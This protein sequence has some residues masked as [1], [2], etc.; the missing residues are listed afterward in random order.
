MISSALPLKSGKIKRKGEKESRLFEEARRVL[1]PPFEWHNFSRVLTLPPS[2]LFGT[3]VVEMAVIAM[4]GNQIIVGET[5]K[6]LSKET[7]APPPLLHVG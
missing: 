2:I 7:N 6:A 1:S 3:E 4:Y 5:T